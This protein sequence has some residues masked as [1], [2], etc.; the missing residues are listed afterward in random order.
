MTDKE[1]IE[2]A[3]ARQG[4]K[5]LSWTN[6]TDGDTAVLGG[7]TVGIEDESDG[8]YEGDEGDLA[9]CVVGA[10][11]YGNR[12]VCFTFCPEGHDEGQEV[13]D[14]SCLDPID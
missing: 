5:I 10:E 2:A 14:L 1:M 4:F 8:L 13:R 12:R 9:A 3:C 6:T 11:K 7:F